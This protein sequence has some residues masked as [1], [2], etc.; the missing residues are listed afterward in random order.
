MSRR[1]AYL[2]LGATFAA[3]VAA[4]SGRG[5][6]IASRSGH[7]GGGDSTDSGAG[8]SGA[9]GS[10]AGLHGT[11]ETTDAGPRAGGASGT[12]GAAVD[13]GVPEGMTTDTDLLI[14]KSG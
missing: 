8:D 4:C 6:V 7:P 14:P 1:L 3:G 13:S 11:A 5:T 9:G 10:G 2:T 12:G